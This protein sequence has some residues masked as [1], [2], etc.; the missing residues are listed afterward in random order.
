MTNLAG[1]TALSTGASS[2]LMTELP[3][4]KQLTEKPIT[5]FTVPKAFKGHIGIIQ[6]NAIKSW[7]L[8]RPQPQIILFGNEEGIDEIA[9]KLRVI[10]VPDIQ[11][12]ECGTPLLNSIFRQAQEL[13]K[14]SILSYVNTDIILLNDFLLAVKQL[15][16]TSFHHFLMTGQRTDV[17]ITESLDFDMPAW[18][19]EL[20]NFALKQG[21]LASAV[22]MD[23]FV[24]PKPLYTEIPSFA[25]GRGYWDHWIFDYAHKLKIPVVDATHVVTAIHQNHNYNHLSGG[26]GAAYVKGNEAKQ[27]AKLAG[28]IHITSGYAATWKLTPLGLKKRKPLSTLF[29]FLVDMP[30]FAK[31]F[32]EVHLT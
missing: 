17:N 3:T 6:Q 1:K 9:N 21:T 5:I 19:T 10:H 32:K 13:A 28:N 11:F 7:T 25:V 31:L 12:N 8:L 27:N 26:R 20:C 22:C 15:Q 18:D 23:Y 4:L 14:N 24:F 16:T 29:S 2:G 30:R